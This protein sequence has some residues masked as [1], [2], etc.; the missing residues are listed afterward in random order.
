MNKTELINAIAEKTEMTKKDTEVFVNTFIKTVTE[1]LTDGEK[2]Q[3]TGFGT[4]DVTEIAEREG[5]N[6]KT[7]EKIIIPEHNR[8]KFKAGKGLKDAVNGR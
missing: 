8:P 5:R 1:A 7:E 2:V 6:P 4:F 3:L